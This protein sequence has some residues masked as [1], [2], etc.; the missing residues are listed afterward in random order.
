MGGCYTKFNDSVRCS[1]DYS[2]ENDNNFL[3]AG[4]V[5]PGTYDAYFWVEGSDQK[6]FVKGVEV[7]PVQS[8][9][10]VNVKGSVTVENTGRGAWFQL[11]TGAT[12]NC[13][14]EYVE[15]KNA[16][17]DFYRYDTDSRVLEVYFWRI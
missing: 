5:P 1:F 17:L 8:M 4:C 6:A 7:K 3:N 13:K 12:G 15:S 9:P 11:R 16:Y 10:A 2:G 14:I